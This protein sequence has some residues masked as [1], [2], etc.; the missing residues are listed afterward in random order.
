MPEEGSGGQDDHML[1]RIGYDRGQP[2][3]R[4]PVVHYHRAS[5][6]TSCTF[7]RSLTK[8][9]NSKAA[10]HR[11]LGRPAF[12]A[13]ICSS[14]SV[15]G[16]KHTDQ[17]QPLAW[18]GYPALSTTLLVQGA[19]GPASGSTLR[20]KSTTRILSESCRLDCHR[21]ARLDRG[22][23]STVLHSSIDRRFTK[24]PVRVP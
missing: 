20:C 24:A 4:A 9:P 15:G 18:L 5:M 7:D 2:N 21:Q 6:T 13:P 22:R 14:A 3:C 16:T 10:R 1:I 11:Y 23:L 19:W 12:L 17:A 8:Y